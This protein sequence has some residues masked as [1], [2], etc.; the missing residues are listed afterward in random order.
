M[1]GKTSLTNTEVLQT[2]YRFVLQVRRDLYIEAE[3]GAVLKN[4]KWQVDDWG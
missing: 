2:T 4:D 1:E 3:L